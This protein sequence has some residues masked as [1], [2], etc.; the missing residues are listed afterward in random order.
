MVIYNISPETFL[1]LSSA[2]KVLRLEPTDTVY[3]FMKQ[4]MSKKRQ[5]NCGD[6]TTEADKKASL[7]NRMQREIKGSRA[8][9]K[10]VLPRGR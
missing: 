2:T 10:L 4:T 3:N 8:L 5:Q 9:C 1:A 6:W 7:E